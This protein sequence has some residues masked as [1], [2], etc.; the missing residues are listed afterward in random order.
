MARNSSGTSLVIVAIVF[1]II[2]WFAN[3]Y[4]AYAITVVKSFV[5]DTFE[6]SAV[7]T[8]PEQQT[9]P[10]EEVMC[11]Q[12]I[13]PARNPQTGDIK[14]FPTPCDV[15]EGWVVIENDVPGL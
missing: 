7:P 3:Q 13:T 9:S 14:E 6:E 11:A 8:I 2:G 4:G 1:L 10:K 12:V 5:A 15:P